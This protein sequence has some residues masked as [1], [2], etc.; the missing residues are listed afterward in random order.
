MGSLFSIGRISLQNYAAVTI[1]P[2]VMV[3][4]LNNHMFGIFG[5][6]SNDMANQNIRALMN[7]HGIVVSNQIFGE[8]STNPVIFAISTDMLTGTTTISIKNM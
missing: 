1:S 2:E 3:A 5:S 4:A 7:K 6:I 8:G